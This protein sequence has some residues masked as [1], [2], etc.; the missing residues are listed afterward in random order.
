MLVLLLLWPHYFF[1]FLWLAG[2]FLLDPLCVWLGRP[3]I[4]RNLAKGDW[5]TV[6]ALGVGTL[7]CGFFW[8]LWNYYSFPKWIYHVPF[9]GFFRVF[10]MP[11]LGY[12]GYPPFGL[13]LYALAHLLR[14]HWQLPGV[15]GED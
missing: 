12:L 10:E 14:R 15:T 6:V 3:A 1:P 13:A 2:F 7:V 8:E 11:L 9:F 4:L 5:R